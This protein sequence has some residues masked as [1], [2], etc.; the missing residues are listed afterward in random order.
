MTS[1]NRSNE[2]HFEPLLQGEYIDAIDFD[3]SAIRDAQLTVAG[4]AKDA[5]D[6]RYL[7]DLLGLLQTEEEDDV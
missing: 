5:G 4:T 3:E 7:L 2:K 1:V 6:C